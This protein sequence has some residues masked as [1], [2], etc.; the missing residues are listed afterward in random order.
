[1]FG[2]HRGLTSHLVGWLWADLLLGLFVIFLAAAA[3][4]TPE[5]IHSTAAATSSATPRP[6]T[7]PPPQ[8]SRTPQATPTPRFV[9]PRAIEISLPIDA[10]ALLSDDTDRI[11]REQQRI[12]GEVDA[13]LRAT[14]AGRPVAVALVFASYRNAAESDRLTRLVTAA[15]RSASFDSAFIKSYPGAASAS[16]DSTV[17]LELYLFP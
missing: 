9:D 4:P 10:L 2:V 8:P 6:T 3:A 13:R 11:T 12:A 16:G 5:L 15:L 14:A 17:T 7:T 1:M